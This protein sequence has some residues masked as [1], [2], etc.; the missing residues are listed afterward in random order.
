MTRGA[1]CLLHAAMMVGALIAASVPF[2]P[3][4]AAQRTDTVAT[5]A[6]PR[7]VARE[8]TA[9]YNAT[10][11]LRAA[12]QVE[13][14]A[15][16]VIRGDVAV[17]DGPVIVAGRITG[18]LLAINAD[19][20]LRKGARIDGDLLV[21]GGEVEGSEGATIG[22]ELRV[23]HPPLRYRRE[24]DVLVA[25]TDG[26]RITEQWWRRFELGAKPNSNRLELA[27]AGAYNRTEGLPVKI[28][29]V[30]YRDQGWGHLRLNADAI[31]RTGSSF[32][33]AT[34]DVGHIVRGEV[35]VGRRYG[36]TLAGEL[37]DVVTGV[38][39]WHLSDMEAGLAAFLFRRDYRDYYGRHGGRI[40]AALRASENADL[41]LSYGDERWS[42]RPTRNPAT[43][44]NGEL[45]WRENPVLDAGRFHRADARLRIDTR[46]DTFNPW[47]G[48]YVLAEYERSTGVVADAGPTSVGVR[49]SP[50]GPTRYQRGFLDVRR[51]NRLAPDA[52][53]NVR[54]VLGGW[55]GGS[56]LPLERRVSIDGPGTIPGFDFRSGDAPDVG[57]CGSGAVVAGRP[58]QCERIA[59]AQLEYR[60]DLR[61]SLSNGQ[62]GARRTRFRAD[63][64]WVFFADAGRGWLV[65]APGNPIDIGRQAL[66]ALST[67]RT[68]IGAG[69]DFTFFGLYVAKALSAP[70]EPM[71]VFVRLRHRF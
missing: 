7:D 40:V 17:L 54:G 22:G 37:F 71:N 42:A 10:T 8:V 2:T 39:D 16:S 48:W 14:P 15:D 9:L 62:G 24:G 56:P 49:V 41:T 70:Q 68:D 29:P 1:R 44:F 35:R 25:E 32:T 23:Y 11:A 61:L 64:A 13:I 67:Y 36:V 12:E 19:V 27:S 45:S 50:A 59:L 66:P 21:V 47:A 31:L 60:N 65:N 43:L 4:A 18:R 6:L 46:N 51:Y 63:G 38:E 30:L 53:L 26:P 55:L 3:K 33:S 57:T 52:A 69:V 34:A 5:N 58:A 20:L 28:G